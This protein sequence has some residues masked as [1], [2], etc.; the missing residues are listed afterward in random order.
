M[1][2]PWAGVSETLTLTPR[3]CDKCINLNSLHLCGRLGLGKKLHALGSGS[4]LAVFFALGVIIVVGIVSPHEKN[5]ARAPQEKRVR[6]WT[7]STRAPEAAAVH[8]STHP[9]LALLLFAHFFLYVVSIL[10]GIIKIPPPTPK[11]F[12]LSL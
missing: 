7:N 3:S 11:H 8:S 12:S 4:D 6:A 1:C 2:L 10:L 9:L 5:N